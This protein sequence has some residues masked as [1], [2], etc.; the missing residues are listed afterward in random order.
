MRS[1]RNCRLPSFNSRGERAAI[2]HTP[3]IDGPMSED[4]P[5]AGRRAGWTTRF[6]AWLI[7]IVL[8]AALVGLMGD[9]LGVGPGIGTT[10]LDPIA[11]V[12]DGLLLFGYWTVF[13]GRTG[14]SP[15]K[16]VL[17]LRV[18]RVDGEALTYVDAGLQSFGKAF[19]LPLDVLVGW[20]A[21]SEEGQRLFNRLSGT[22]VV[23]VDQPP[24]E[25]G[26]TAT[27]A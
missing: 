8:V 17:E 25:S 15:G 16:L 24:R 5:P 22:M 12:R 6:G 1:V 27:T 23:E 4:G 20:L 10:F 2:S 7:D 21:M 9:S 19:L 26:A 11:R 14:Q 3:T 13:E 18:V